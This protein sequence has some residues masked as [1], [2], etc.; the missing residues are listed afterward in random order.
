MY[1]STTITGYVGRD[2]E[3]R[4]LPSGV[5][6]TKFSVAVSEKRGDNKIT[7]W[8]N[9]STFGKLAET[10]NTY[11]K[12]GMLVLCEGRLNCDPLTGGPKVWLSQDG[13]SRA[14]YELSANNVRFL[15]RVDEQAAPAEIVNDDDVPF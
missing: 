13:T 3:M 4:Y 15:S 11:V 9:V 2:P 10:C 7:T 14:S 12:K 8:F 6:T 5:A 1:Q